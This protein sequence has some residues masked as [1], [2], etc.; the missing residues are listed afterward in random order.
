MKAREGYRC[1]FPGCP[2]KN[3]RLFT[4]EGLRMHLNNVHNFNFSKKDFVSVMQFGE[5]R[6]ESEQ[7]KQKRIE[8]Y[9]NN[10]KRF[11]ET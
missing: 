1:L 8:K 11:I 5:W 10:I 2:K 9:I 7:D 4:Q 6:E 3:N